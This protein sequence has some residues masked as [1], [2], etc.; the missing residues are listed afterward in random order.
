METLSS[1]PS[2]SCRAPCHCRASLH[3]ASSTAATTPRPCALPTATLAGAAPCPAC[4]HP[5]CTPNTHLLVLWQQQHQPNYQPG[6]SM[7]AAP[8]ASCKHPLPTHHNSSRPT[9][10]AGVY[11][12]CCH[13]PAA[14]CAPA[15]R[16]P[17]SNPSCS[18]SKTRLSTN[19]KTPT[20]C[21]TT[22]TFWTLHKHTASG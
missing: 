3:Q 16:L 1:H 12:Q 20:A 9:A 2:A 15:M 13:A 10:L 5:A 22:I 11:L 6:T 19:S 18:I 8:T 4:R 17:A 7:Q 14:A 21:P